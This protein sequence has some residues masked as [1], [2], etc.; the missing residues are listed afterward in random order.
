MNLRLSI[1]VAI[2]CVLAACTR[3][4]RDASAGDAD[5]AR[6]VPQPVAI[7]VAEAR[8]QPI[9]TRVTV[10]GDV[11]APS[12]A[13]DAGFA[14]Q[15]DSAGIY[16]AADI[17]SRATVG[18]RMRVTGTLADN[19]GF[20]VIRPEAVSVIGA[21]SLPLFLVI[22]SSIIGERTEGL[23][24]WVDGRIAE[25][26]VD[27]RPYGWKIMLENVFGRV[28]IFVPAQR[29]FDPAEYRPGRWISVNGIS[30]QY[31]TKSLLLLCIWMY[32]GLT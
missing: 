30:A 4:S 10:V 8:K 25:P 13:I 20:L 5:T 2:A 6:A 16:I 14:I 7:S 21:G 18:Q 19:H 28:Q 29:P 9:G 15:Q 11:T 17:S 31:D 26:V 12:G 23:P 22:P 32:H 24:A 1:Y 3:P 27:D